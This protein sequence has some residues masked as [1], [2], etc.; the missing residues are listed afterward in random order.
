MAVVLMAEWD[1]EI[2][3]EGADHKEEKDRLRREIRE[4]AEPFRRALELARL[5]M[6]HGEN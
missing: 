2:R 3:V 1:N 5:M 4:G 6:R